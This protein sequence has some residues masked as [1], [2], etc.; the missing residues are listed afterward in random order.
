MQGPRA[1]R[2]AD[3]AR[4]RR[5]VR[6]ACTSSGWRSRSERLAV[7]GASCGRGPRLPSRSDRAADPVALRPRAWRSSSGTPGAL[8]HFAAAADLARRAGDVVGRGAL[9]ILTTQRRQWVA[10]GLRAHGDSRQPHTRRWR[11][12]SSRARCASP[13]RI[14]A[15]RSAGERPRHSRR[16]RPHYDGRFAGPPA[17][18]PVELS[19]SLWRRPIPRRRLSGAARVLITRVSPCAGIGRPAAV[20][21]ACDSA[22]AWPGGARSG[23]HRD[24]PRLCALDRSAPR[25]R[26]SAGPGLQLVDPRPLLLVARL[27][28]PASP[29]RTTSRSHSSDRT[30]R[31]RQLLDAMVAT[32]RRPARARVALLAKSSRL[33]TTSAA[34]VRHRCRAD[35]SRE[36]A[37][38]SS[39][40]VTRRHARRAGARSRPPARR[41]PIVRGWW[42]PERDRR[43]GRV[44]L[45]DCCCASVERS[46]CRAT[47][48]IIVADGPL[49]HLP[50]LRSRQRRRPSPHASPRP[51]AVGYG[52]VAAAHGRARRVPARC[53]RWPIHWM[54]ACRPPAEE[55]DSFIETQQLGP[56]PFAR[57]EGRQRWSASPGEQAARRTAGDRAAFHQADPA[58]YAVLHFASHALVDEE[59]PHRRRF[60]CGGPT[61]GLL[62]VP[63]I[64]GCT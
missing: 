57:R 35:L 19:E 1:L 37:A 23:T 30:L 50:C 41:V 14:G 11:S 20:A 25:R 34:V 64:A 17:A 15:G 44:R 55:R 32:V 49:H 7:A 5:R 16:R 33:A 27:L 21:Y 59:A 62:Q 56:L 63:E 46:A 38:R 40:V 60:S 47:R 22:C 45:H 36:P 24:D 3:A 12:P 42:K 51:G 4:R 13:A 48:L 26:W 58:S 18:D 61:D 52:V 9:H 29:R 6:H 8:A 31:A 10:A 54:P 39:V 28:P 43:I 2:V 53:S